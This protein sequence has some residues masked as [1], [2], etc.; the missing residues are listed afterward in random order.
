MGCGRE[1]RRRWRLW[2]VVARGMQGRG[3]ATPS[4]DAAERGS[5]ATDDGCAA[6]ADIRGRWVDWQVYGQTRSLPNGSFG[7]NCRPSPRFSGAWQVRRSLSTSNGGRS[8]R[9]TRHWRRLRRFTGSTA[10]L[11][12]A[13]VRR[14]PRSRRDR[15]NRMNGCDREAFVASFPAHRDTAPAQC[16]K[17]SPQHRSEGFALAQRAGTRAHYRTNQPSCPTIRVRSCG[18]PRFLR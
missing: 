14:P 15:Y 3:T 4:P 13:H 8:L 1:Q 16:S 5:V 18:A 2:R 9:P 10:S 6:E 11:R 7:V 17:A 12:R